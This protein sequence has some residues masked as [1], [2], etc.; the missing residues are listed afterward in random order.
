MGG[1]FATALAL[2]GYFFFEPVSPLTDFKSMAR[3]FL[4]AIASVLTC[5]CLSFFVV[6]SVI[7]RPWCFGLNVVQESLAP[8][9]KS[10]ENSGTLNVGESASVL[11]RLRVLA[12]RVGGQGQDFHA[13]FYF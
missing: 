7:C 5:F 9:W 4:S 1:K 10:R 13:G 11:T 12:K 3:C 8:E 6:I 2:Q